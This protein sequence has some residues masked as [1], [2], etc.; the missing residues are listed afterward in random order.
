MD[1]LEG[2]NLL[3]ADV[4]LE[5]A[6]DVRL[7]SR[8]SAAPLCGSKPKEPFLS[9][10]TLPNGKQITLLKSLL[11][12][13][14]ERNCIYCPFRAGRDTR[15]VT[16]KPDEMAST[17]M[18]LH[19]AGIVEG[20]FLSSGIIGGGSRTQ[21]KII[22][23]AEILRQKYQYQGYM[24]LKLMPGIE[25][26]QVERTMQLA[27]RVSVNLEA[28]NAHR[29]E[30]LAPRKMFIEEL[31]QPLRW[32]EEIRVNQPRQK[33]WKGRWPS[34][35]TQFV[36]GA[37]G[38][39]DL[40]LISTTESLIHQVRLQRAYYSAFRPIARTPLENMPGE[41]PLR[42]NRLYQASFLLR[43]YGFQL[44]ELP[45]DENGKLPLNV[46][47]KA[48]WAQENLIHCPIEINTVDRQELLR[49]P[50]IGP[51]GAAR[52]LQARRREP[53]RSLEDLRRLGISVERS[54]PYILLNG[55]QPARQL[56]FF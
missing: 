6:E 26:A 35:T 43:D 13:A 10:A 24:H 46:D 15:R 11:S 9:Q 18:S 44:E 3:S 45:F 22:A 29:L 27:D 49:I 56:R 38:E 5:P 33:G 52:I 31:I 17:F 55:V 14:C 41:N 42:Q 53:I 19:Q 25:R 12:T 37:A 16:F 28:P 32:V 39:T 21:D 8:T 20:I 34:I 23:V 50:G 2:L 40:E 7:Q 36:V 48:A 1:A 4:D 30:I 47:P 54:S 51:S